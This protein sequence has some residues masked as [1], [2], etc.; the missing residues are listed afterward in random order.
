MNKHF[1]NTNIEVEEG[2]KNYAK[3]NETKG[4]VRKLVMNRT[5]AKGIM[6]SSIE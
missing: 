2:R 3:L 6:G 1:N 5:K 4:G